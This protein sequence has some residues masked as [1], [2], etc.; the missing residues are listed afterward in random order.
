[1]NIREMAIEFVRNNPGC[2]STQIANGAGIPKRM[3]QPLMTELY[4]QEIVNRYALE[5]HPFHYLIPK[6]GERPNLGERYEKHRAKATQLENGGLWRRAAREWLLAMDAT[7][8][9]EARDKAANRREYC[10]SQG[11]I[12]V[13]HETSGIGVISVPAIDMWRN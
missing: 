13:Q 8:N 9:E 5:A 10:I 7:S 2:T 1:M 12:G 4:T 11:C 3:I 6:E